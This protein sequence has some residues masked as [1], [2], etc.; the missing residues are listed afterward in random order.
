MLIVGEV[1]VKL[2]YVMFPILDANAVFVRVKKVQLSE[3]T[4]VTRSPIRPQKRNNNPNVWL[5]TCLI[6]QWH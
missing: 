6:V 2:M 4:L 5:L 3:T 1:S